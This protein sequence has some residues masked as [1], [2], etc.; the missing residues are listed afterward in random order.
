MNNLDEFATSFHAYTEMVND[1]ASITFMIEARVFNSMVEIWFK[2]LAMRKK[3]RRNKSAH[4]PH[5]GT[6]IH[7]FCRKLPQVSTRTRLAFDE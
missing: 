7:K 1:E 3:P 6:H 5:D 4:L 2:I